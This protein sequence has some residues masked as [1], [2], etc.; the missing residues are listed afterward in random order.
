MGLPSW[1][2]KMEIKQEN[3]VL[4]DAVL[5]KGHFGEVRA[6][7]VTIQGRVTKAAIKTLKGNTMYAEEYMELN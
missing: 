7:K 3:L 5:G 1:M 6:G 2:R 4:D